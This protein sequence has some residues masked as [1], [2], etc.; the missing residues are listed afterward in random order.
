MTM[1]G[2]ESEGTTTDAPLKILV[3]FFHELAHGAAAVL[4]GGEIVLI[5]L[6]PDQG[7][8][9]VTRGGSRTLIL[10]AGYLGSLL[11]GVALL[12]GA[13]NS[14]ADRAI[15]A[16]LLANNGRVEMSS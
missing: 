2:D 7:G 8:T 4:T 10:T 14:H 3:V 1:L 9:A 12:L 6:S 15:M 5:T 11:I 16:A 13:L